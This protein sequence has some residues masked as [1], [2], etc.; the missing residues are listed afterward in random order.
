MR[1]CTGCSRCIAHV[2]LDVGDDDDRNAL[3]TPVPVPEEPLDWLRMHLQT[4]RNQQPWA[5]RPQLRDWLRRARLEAY[6]S[7]FGQASQQADANWVALQARLNAAELPGFRR[8]AE[9]PGA[10]ANPAPRQAPAA[11]EA[12][13]G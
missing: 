8:M 6:T 13:P 2:A 3:C 11:A 1:S 10:A 4:M 9:L 7:M 12:A 5:L